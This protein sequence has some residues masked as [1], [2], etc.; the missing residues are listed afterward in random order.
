MLETSLA[1][2][3]LSGYFFKRVAHL[4]CTIFS[5]YYFKN[6]SSSVKLFVDIA[7]QPFSSLVIDFYADLSKNGN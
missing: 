2:I 4:C 6:S 3:S 5:H 1:S 7:R